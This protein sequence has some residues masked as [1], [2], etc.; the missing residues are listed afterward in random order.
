MELVSL[1]LLITLKIENVKRSLILVIY[2]TSNVTMIFTLIEKGFNKT[3]T[4]DI[5]VTKQR[6]D[7]RKIGKKAIGIK[8]TNTYL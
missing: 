3:S 1:N 5:E 8:A 4:V 7:N 6:V 2:D